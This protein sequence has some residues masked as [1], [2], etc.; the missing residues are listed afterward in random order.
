MRPRRLLVLDE[1]EARLDQAGLERLTGRLLQEKADGL[2]YPARQSRPRTRGGGCR[3]GPR[4]RL[5]CQLS[6]STA[7][8]RT[9]ALPDPDL[10][11]VGATPVEL[12]ARFRAIFGVVIGARFPVSA[13]FEKLAIRR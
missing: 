10:A 3:P 5:R 1:P 8:V 4:P 9:A 11:P 7:E 6:A 2:G 12:H 13:S